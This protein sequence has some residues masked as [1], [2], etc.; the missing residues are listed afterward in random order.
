MSDVSKE[1][2]EALYELAKTEGLEDQLLEET[3]TAAA[4]FKELA[5][6]RID[7]RMIDQGSSGLNIIIGVDES[8]YED[9][10]RACYRVLK[11]F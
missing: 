8:A 5:D 10:V 2:G 11:S 9:A 4:V 6:S 3:R 1:Y 7:I